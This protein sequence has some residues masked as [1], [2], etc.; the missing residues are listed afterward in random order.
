LL[1]CR[2]LR[3]RD[4]FQC[5][6]A[7]LWHQR[8]EVPQSRSHGRAHSRR[9]EAVSQ[10][11]CLFIADCLAVDILIL[12][13]DSTG[14]EHPIL[15]CGLRRCHVELFR[16]HGLSQRGRMSQLDELLQRHLVRCAATPLQRSSHDLLEY[17]NRCTW[18]DAAAGA[19]DPKVL[20]RGSQGCH[21]PLRR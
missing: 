14:R 21:E 9:P 13:A 12:R 18:R 19:S 6:G 16:G 15:R 20:R 3:L 17:A 10:P 2:S 11:H 8:R 7:V 5:R 1:D 4:L